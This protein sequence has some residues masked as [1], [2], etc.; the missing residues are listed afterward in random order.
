MSKF[1]YCIAGQWTK[2]FTYKSSSESIKQLKRINK[3]LSLGYEQDAVNIASDFDR[4]YMALN[5]SFSK[6][7]KGS[8]L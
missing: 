8:E 4:V 1:I 5:K 3:N 2:I 6:L 7:Q